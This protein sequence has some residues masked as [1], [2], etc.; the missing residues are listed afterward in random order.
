MDVFNHVLSTIETNKQIRDR[1][2]FT[3][4]PWLGMPRFSSV[5]PG[6]QRSK[7]TI[8]TA[9]SKVGKTQLADYLYMYQPLEFVE[10]YP[11]EFDLKIFYFSLEV[12]K[13]QKIK[14][15]LAHKLY[16]D[17]KIVITPENLESHFK[18]YI[19][20]DQTLNTIKEYGPYFEQF[21]KRV[22]F[23][24]N[25]RT[26]T[27]IYRYMKK[28][29]EHNGKYV[30]KNGNKVSIDDEKR[31]RYIPDNPKEFV[32]VLIDHFSLFS[33]PQGASLHHAMTTFS[34][35]YALQ[36]RDLWNYSVV[37]IQQQAADQEKVKLDYK[38]NKI[39]DKLKPSADGLGDCKLTGRDCDLML[40]LFAPVRYNINT[41]K[42]VDITQLGD[43]YR[44]LSVILNRHGS[45]M[46]TLGMFFHGGVTYFEELPREASEILY[47]HYDSLK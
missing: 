32:I 15:A 25:V 21:E 14:A 6:V 2:G 44:E 37:G 12:S 23:I 27:G 31:H 41:Y 8:V 29:A 16:K 13:E 28:Y 7:Y 46:Q 39:V 34:N 5:I 43:H 18:D 1:G 33:P 24:D 40:G 11:D 19:I 20:S 47:F 3:C 38:G 17:K 22:R 35:S 30:D 4:I 10:Q 9:N 42:G 26:P 45:A 36:M